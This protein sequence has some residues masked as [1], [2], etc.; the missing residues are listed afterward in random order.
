MYK[1]CYFGKYIQKQL[2]K[3]DGDTVPAKTRTIPTL[4]IHDIKRFNTT[5]LT[6]PGV[7][8]CPYINRIYLPIETRKVPVS[9]QSSTIIDLHLNEWG[10]TPYI[11]LDHR[12]FKKIGDIIG[13]VKL[14]LRMP[15]DMGHLF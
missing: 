14:L 6:F 12:C 7:C 15:T 4:G 1:K 13:S 10:K 8:C 2:V 11:Y 9:T 3:D 5:D